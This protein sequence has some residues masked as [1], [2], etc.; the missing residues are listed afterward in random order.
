MEDGIGSLE[1]GALAVGADVEA[2]ALPGALED[3]LVE[4][5]PLGHPPE[6][7]IL[8]L[9][10]HDERCMTPRSRDRTCAI[11]GVETAQFLPL[12]PGSG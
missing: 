11:R 9:P 6:L 2:G 3:A 7:I 4:G 5:G 10:S 1:G 8:R 12:R